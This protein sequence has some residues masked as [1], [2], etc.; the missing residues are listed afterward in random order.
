MRCMSL[1]SSQGILPL[2]V[3]IEL[4]IADP[5]EVWNANDLDLT[6]NHYRR[7]SVDAI[8]F[9]FRFDISSHAVHIVD[10]FGAAS[11]LP[12]F[13][14]VDNVSTLGTIC[15]KYF[16]S[17]SLAHDLTF[18]WLGFKDSEGPW[19]SRNPSEV[20]GVPRKSLEPEAAARRRTGESR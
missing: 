7:N 16:D 1:C 6:I 9:H 17:V 19:S 18:V 15:G 13:D 11:T 10:D 4:I 12:D 8:L 3:L 2:Q 14:D 5:G 20:V